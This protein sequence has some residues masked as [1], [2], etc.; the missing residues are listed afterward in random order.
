VAVEK[1]FLK[2]M[3]RY[4]LIFTRI[5]HISFLIWM[6]GTPFTNDYDNLLMHSSLA[7][8]L[9]FHWIT[10]NDTCAVTEF[11]KYMSGKVKNESTFVGSVISPIYK[12]TFQK[13]APDEYHYLRLPQLR[14]IKMSLLVLWYLSLKKVMKRS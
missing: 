12:L 6:I 13:D 2:V 8:F 3:S 9:L 1:V 4:W 11:E 5:L 10:N 7:P 14:V